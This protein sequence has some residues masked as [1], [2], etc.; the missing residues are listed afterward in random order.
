[1]ILIVKGKEKDNEQ[2]DDEGEKN[3]DKFGLKK[4][5]QILIFLVI[6]PECS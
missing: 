1:M 4:N 2:E 5:F 3:I 6:F